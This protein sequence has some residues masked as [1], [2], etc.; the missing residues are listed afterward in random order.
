MLCE[1]QICD[2]KSGF[3]IKDFTFQLTSYIEF[4]NEDYYV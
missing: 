3:H 1:A 2:E 4:L